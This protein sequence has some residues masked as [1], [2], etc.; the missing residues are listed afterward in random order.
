MTANQ[1]RQSG[2]P[3]FTLRQLQFFVAV[4][5]AGSISGAA[6]RLFV[7]ETA[8][9]LA[10][11]QLEKVLGTR[12]L[13]RRRAH[14]VELTAAGDS[15]LRS[16]RHL[17]AQASDLH[18]ELSGTGAVRGSVNVGCFPSLGPTLLPLLMHDFLA[19]Y[20]E[21]SMSFHDG[22]MEQMEQ[23]TLVGSLDLMISYDVSLSAGFHKVVLSSHRPGVL[24]S[25][26]HWAA[27]QEGP[28]SVLDLAA[29]PFIALETPLSVEHRNLVFQAAGTAP[30]IR[31]SSENFETVRS[32]VGRGF[33][34]TMLL[35]RPHT[36]VTHEGTHVVQRELAYPAVDPVSVVLAWSKAVP[37]SRA[38]TAFVEFASSQSMG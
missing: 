14:G 34:W 29:E 10:V 38:A 33:G 25:A 23:H 12:L 16:A 27:Q 30:W 21:A 26:N 9:S 3:P 37:L 31:Y 6:G 22:P 15:V 4:A 13:I 5:D 7:S 32:L 2:S 19:A 18:E 8:V 11:S 20:P 28:V 17:L 24:I 1:G 35:Q 36:N